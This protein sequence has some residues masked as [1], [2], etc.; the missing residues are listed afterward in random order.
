M[1]GDVALSDSEVDELTPAAGGDT[2]LCT[3]TMQF[4]AVASKPGN[5][6]NTVVV[7]SPA[8]LGI[9]CVGPAWVS[10]GYRG[11]EKRGG[12][13]RGSPP[14]FFY[15]PVD[16]AANCFSVRGS[17]RAGTARRVPAPRMRRSHESVRGG[18]ACVHAPCE[19]SRVGRVCCH[20]VCTCHVAVVP[21]GDRCRQQRACTART[22]RG[23]VG[24]PT[25]P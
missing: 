19:P 24:I 2:A 16:R 25:Q 22:L 7:S 6:T 12:S 10:C 14:N 20:R 9:L 8:E 17:R 18:A 15:R 5:V 13:H 3:L 1:G 23:P 11:G 21:C 4:G